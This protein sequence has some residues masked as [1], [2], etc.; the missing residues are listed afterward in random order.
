MKQRYLSAILFVV[1]ILC[2]AG[3]VF[4]KWEK[5]Q[6]V[7]ETTPSWG[8]N[9]EPV[10]SYRNPIRDFSGETYIATDENYDISLQLPVEFEP[11]I[12][13]LN[14]KMEQV[15]FVGDIY[16]IQVESTSDDH[17]YTPKY[18]VTMYIVDK[19]DIKPDSLEYHY[20]GL[21]FPQIKNLAINDSLTYS[22]Y[23]DQEK[24][25]YFGENYQNLFTSDEV[26]TRQPDINRWK[27]YK[28]VDYNESSASYGYRA[29]LEDESYYFSV[30]YSTF[31]ENL[32]SDKILEDIIESKKDIFFSII[33]N[34]QIN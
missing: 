19:M 28:F 2:V 32:A 4:L 22:R 5:A 34:T 24:L 26:Y 23:S 27:V 13:Q 8:D 12:E 25:E 31:Y 21:I 11:S 1:V 20:E 16:N 30:I 10:G 33:E 15:S 18:A 29:T 3:A 17:E 9:S 7:E 14:L 6:Q